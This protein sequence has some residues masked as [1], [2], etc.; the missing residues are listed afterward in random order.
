MESYFGKQIARYKIQKAI[1][2]GG[3]AVVYLAEDTTLHRQ[4]ALKM[5][6]T[7][8]IPPSQLPRL[9]ERFKREAEA[10]A[11][12]SDDPAIVTVHDYGEFEGIP[13][14]VMAYMPRGSLKDNLNGRLDYRLAARLLIPVAEALAEAHTLGII[15]RDIKPS[16][17]LITR[18]GGLALADFG[19]AKALELDG[20]T[21]T[22]TGMGVGT[23]EYMAPEQWKGEAT[24]RSDIYSLG[25]VLY[26]M[27]TGQKPYSGRTP[28]DI[29]LKQ[30]TEAPVR[31]RQLAPDLPVSVE[32]LLTKILIRDAQRRLP[33]MTALRDALEQLATS[34]P[35][36]SKAP[37]MPALDTQ[38]ETRDVLAGVKGETWGADGKPGVSQPPETGETTD[39]W[40]KED[41]PV[42]KNSSLTADQLN[43]HET[44]DELQG[45]QVPG[46]E[47]ASPRKSSGL[48]KG[49]LA[50][51][52]GMALIVLIAAYA[53]GF[54]SPRM[55]ATGENMPPTAFVQP[56]KS[57][58]STS[59]LAT[60][61]RAVQGASVSQPTATARP[62]VINAVEE[63]ITA[64]VLWNRAIMRIGPGEN[65][66][67]LCYLDK[68]FEVKIVG[69]NNDGSW[70]LVELLPG[71]NCYTLNTSGKKV[72]QTIPAGQQIWVSSAS[73]EILKSIAGVRV[74]SSPPTET[75]IVLKVPIQS[76]G[77][78]D[79]G[80]QYP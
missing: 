33:S 61:T 30:M 6:R 10:L 27:V 73:L 50:A 15:H 13:Y 1:G 34:E 29:F 51:F 19:I 2:E 11:Q 9:M 79:D 58:T 17:L 5:I 63:T 65:Y 7:S 36:N 56:V 32:S 4:V 46:I 31:P 20:Q 22:G 70:L 71:N 67:M 69:R 21:L 47:V 44:R 68:G 14:L 77:S 24:P 80:G 62:N 49:L 75:P 74:V 66:R 16:N 26:E 55:A 28:S 59:V 12:L 41:V 39:I 64:R 45:R 78:N 18:K 38:E 54:F 40:R 3:M 53:L 72:Y 35:E 48:W 43:L 60:Q 25:V 8:E 42:S 76:S 52:A 23:P 57:R 37:A